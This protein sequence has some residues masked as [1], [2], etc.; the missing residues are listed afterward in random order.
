MPER[1]VVP[2]GTGLLAF[3]LRELTWVLEGLHVFPARMREN[4]E[5]GGGI[6]YSQAV[7]LALVDAGMPRDEA[8]ALVQRAA[9]LA[10]DD[11][12]SFR[13]ALEADPAVAARLD[14]PAL[15]RL[16][17]PARS[18]ANLGHV[19]EKLEKLPVEAE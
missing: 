12:R 19:F 5:T 15:D 10:W 9:A 13:E 18:L 16:F 17:D 2:D 8:Y 3:M 4:L 14:V 6:V 1:I 11:A 7:L